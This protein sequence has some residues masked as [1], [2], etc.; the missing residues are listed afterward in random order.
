MANGLIQTPLYLIISFGSKKD[1]NSTL[2]MALMRMI[3][4]RQYNNALKMSAKHLMSYSE[5]N[6][7]VIMNEWK[8]MQ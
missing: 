4:A 6:R 8:E 5:S 1:E 3:S 2:I 7:K